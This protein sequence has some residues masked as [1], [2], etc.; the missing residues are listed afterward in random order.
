MSSD[1]ANCIREILSPDDGNPRARKVV[2]RSKWS[3]TF[4][5]PTPKAGRFVEAESWPEFN[6]HQL[7]QA[8]PT[9]VQF[10]E[11]PLLIRYV[12]NGIPREHFPD[13]RVH[14][15]DHT[16]E[17]WEIKRARDA[18][19]PA[20]MARTE[21]LQRELAGR[22]K[23]RIV[24]A[25]SLIRQPRANNI[26]LLLWLGAHRVDPLAREHLRQLAIQADGIPW[27]AA[28]TGALGPKGPFALCSLTLA[29]TLSI[30]LNS[31]IRPDTRFRLA[32][33]PQ[34]I[35]P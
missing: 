33:A 1:P 11:Q 31:P 27:K 28:C 29:G 4:K 6:A 14:R 13:A 22:Y 25:E 10:A 3:F 2:T 17:L 26:R 19:S 23:Y 34:E 24:L 16:V 20:V 21:L 32:G 7:L 18:F 35:I 8:D 9:V 12:L 5:L 15:A 30:D